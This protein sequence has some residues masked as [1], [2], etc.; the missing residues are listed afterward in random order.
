MYTGMCFYDMIGAKID[1]KGFIMKQ[2]LIKKRFF[3]WLACL[4]LCMSGC[5]KTPVEDNITGAPTPSPT[6]ESLSAEATE[7]TNVAEDDNNENIL[8]ETKDSQGNVTE[9]IEIGRAHV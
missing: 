2:R 8:I 1:F 5:G 7:S 3:L 4:T 9:K 6:P